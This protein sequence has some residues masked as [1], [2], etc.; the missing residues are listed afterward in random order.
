MPTATLRTR[1]A[2]KQRAEA[3]PGRQACVRTRL[4]E[5]WQ[6]T[7]LVIIAAALVLLNALMAVGS[8]R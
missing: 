8:E 1:R 2:E 3:E 7:S 5:E 4:N 6:M